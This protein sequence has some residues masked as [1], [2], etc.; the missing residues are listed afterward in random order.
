MKLILSFA[1]I[2]QSMA[3]G[4]E[5]TIE[6]TRKEIYNAEK[7]VALVMSQKTGMDYG[8]LLQSSGLAT[9]AVGGAFVVGGS[10]PRSPT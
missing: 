8:E 6:K 9:N 10:F 5:S 3:L 1:L 2:M 7:A 4:Q